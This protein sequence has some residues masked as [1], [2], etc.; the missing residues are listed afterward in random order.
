V[1]AREKFLVERYRL[2]ELP[3]HLKEEVESLEEF[4]KEMALLDRSDEQIRQEFH[5]STLEHKIRRNKIKR[6]L[7]FIT[8]AAVLVLF[9]AAGWIFLN[10]GSSNETYRI[11]GQQLTEPALTLYRHHGDNVEILRDG[12]QASRGDLIQIGYK[13]IPTGSYG[14]ILSLD[15]A[16]NK[17]V[18][19][20]LSG[21]EA[22]PLESGTEVYLPWSYE[23]DNAP[24]Y[25]AFFLLLSNQPFQMKDIS[26]AAL[27]E[28]K[29]PRGVDVY[30]F[31]LTKED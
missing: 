4:G 11:K 12:A 17:T 22:Q 13:G 10:P 23:L 3:D 14:I 16:G 20:P 28:K 21:E 26:A 1:T 2:N 19:Y 9:F 15:G 25:E 31:M 24:E 5:F 6:N 18:H 29:L 27:L 8:A 7:Q 30:G